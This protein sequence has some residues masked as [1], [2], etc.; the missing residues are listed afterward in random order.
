MSSLPA[1]TPG[2]MAA[3][4]GQ[5]RA[6]SAHACPPA[7]PCQRLVATVGAISRQSAL[8]RPYSSEKTTIDPVESPSPTT[9]LSAP[10]TNTVAATVAIIAAPISGPTPGNNVANMS[11]TP[12]FRGLSLAP[13]RGRARS[14]G[15]E[16][17]TSP[18][19]V[20]EPRPGGR[21]LSLT[22]RLLGDPVFVRVVGLACERCTKRPTTGFGGSA[23]RRGT[24]VS[25]PGP[26]VR[27][28][29]PT[30]SSP[31]LAAK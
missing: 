25:M 15:A 28:A 20:H 31:N 29:Q 22:R 27:V 18:P 23:P 26:G 21:C 30:L 13:A 4:P 10:V 12:S 14:L 2:T 24:G 5:N 16:A 17:T 11:F 7:A 9:P 19:R 6:T 3:S 8:S 1:H